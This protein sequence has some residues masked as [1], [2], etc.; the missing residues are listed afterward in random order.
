M[1]H[2]KIRLKGMPYNMFKTVTLLLML[3]ISI[4][5]FANDKKPQRESTVFNETFSWQAQGGFALRQG[6]GIYQDFDPSDLNQPFAVTLLVDFY[7]KGFF[8][9]SDHWR[10]LT[11]SLGAEF[12]YQLMVEDEWELDIIYRS[13]IA[14]LDI[15]YIFQ[16]TKKDIPILAGLT[17]RDT[18]NG[19]GLRYSRYLDNGVLSF[20]LA[21][22]QPLS[23]A[24]G[25]VAEVFYSHII[26]YR[27]WDI[28]INTGLTYFSDKAMDYFTGV[29]Q[30]EV[31]PIRAEYQ[32]EQSVKAQFEVFAQ[33]PISQSWTVN[34]GISHNYYLSDIDESP[35]IERNNTTQFLI[36]VLYVF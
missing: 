27:N 4:Q 33:R 34:L 32:G 26:P 22:F 31:T 23:D 1:N 11:H 36:G 10:I 19:I 9:E 13:Y 21:S 17:P 20:D 28:Y 2:I 24:E 25:W 29:D 35:I 7:Y 18:G 12:G 30:N 16:Q 15:N 8:I 3:A 14:G 6:N 5:S